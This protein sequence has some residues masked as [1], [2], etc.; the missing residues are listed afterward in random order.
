MTLGFTRRRLPG[1]AE[2]VL[3]ALLSL[4][5]VTPAVAEP[6]AT[7]PAATAP[8]AA[9]PASTGTESTPPFDAGALS[10]RL[11]RSLVLVQAGDARG[12]GV[13]FGSAGRVLVAYAVIDRADAPVVTLSDGSSVAAHVVDWNAHAGVALLELEGARRGEPLALAAREPSVGDAIVSPDLVRAPGAS[14]HDAVPLVALLG[15]GTVS[16]VSAGLLWVDTPVAPDDLGRPIVS[17]AGE[18]LGVVVANA[19]AEGDAS[20]GSPAAPSGT[21]ARSA[22]RRV[23]EPLASSSTVRTDFE[24]TSRAHWEVQRGLITVPL[25]S[26]GL[27]GAGFQ[28]G[29]RR[30]WFV[31]LIREGFLVSGFAP[32]STTVYERVQRRAFFELE[33]QAQVRFGRTRLFGGG[34]AVILADNVDTRT[35]DEMGVVSDDREHT[36]RVRPLASIG[37]NTDPLEVGFAVYIS[38]EIESR[39]S[40]GLIWGR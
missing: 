36:I 33:L 34:G 15:S 6:A 23:L 32:Q 25:A 30:E 7:A 4:L 14:E 1:G 37:L 11:A 9:E 27:I 40:I 5:A 2:S 10:A 16:G 35:V 39:L 12:V 18:L 31:A 13:F 22:G 29:Y 17:R 38:D 21:R 24:P 3:G 19:D 28:F 8:A 20:A 26:D